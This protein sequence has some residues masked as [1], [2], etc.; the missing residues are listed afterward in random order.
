MKEELTLDMQSATERRQR[1][2]LCCFGEGRMGVHGGTDIVCRRTILETE[3]DFGDELRHIW[4]DEMRAKELVGARVG[5]ELHES[6]ALAHRPRAAVRA[7][8][9][10]ADAIFATALFDFA[11]GEPDGS[12]FGPRIDDVWDRAIMH[13]HLLPGNVLAGD[14]AF[15]L[16]LVREHRA[17]NA[18]ADCIHVRHSRSHRVV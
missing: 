8:R 5:D 4:S 12:D 10:F 11:L 13:V 9:E 16:R 15:F 2:L 14:D 17:G 1:R 3:Y 7:E 6:A 18:V